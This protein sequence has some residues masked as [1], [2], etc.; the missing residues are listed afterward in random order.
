MFLQHSKNTGTANRVGVV[1]A[2]LIAVVAAGSAIFGSTPMP[3]SASN[4]NFSAI[5]K[6]N[7]VFNTKNGDA[8]PASYFGNGEVRNSGETFPLVVNGAP[9]QDYVLPK[10]VPGLSVQRG[11]GFIKIS[12]DSRR[13]KGKEGAAGYITINGSN[14][15]SISESG[16]PEKLED[17]KKRDARLGKILRDEAVLTSS[18]SARFT[19]TA[20]PKIDTFTIW[21]ATPAVVATPTA[22]PV[23]TSTPVATATP[24]PTAT[25]VVTATPVPTATPVVT[26]DIYATCVDGNGNVIVVTS[27]SS[28]NCNVNVN[29]QNI[30]LNINNSSNNSSSNSAKSENSGN[31][32]QVVTAAAA[33]RVAGAAI[34]QVIAHPT[35]VTSR[36]T[37][38]PVT[39]K[40]GAG[41][42]GA[43]L[44][45]TISGG[46]GL[47]YMVRR[48]LI[49]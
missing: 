17:R 3:A 24:I 18:T 45:S 23:P 27:G 9:V 35:R 22:T 4:E 33:P 21:Y 10:N 43:I 8:T 48:A 30:E 46:S 44:F 49:G 40:T 12:M 28:Q 14:F 42:L 47:A 5:I 13:T 20:G 19:L 1:A 26:R 36:P 32:V 25:P 31:N 6:I 7:E 2:S 29:K 15:V 11:N 16:R 34:A 38:V 37:A 41:D 39:A